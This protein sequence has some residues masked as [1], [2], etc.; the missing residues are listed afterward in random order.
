MSIKT[1]PNCGCLYATEHGEMFGGT[2]CRC[3]NRDGVPNDIAAL[4]AELAAAK[5]EIVALRTPIENLREA[6]RMSGLPTEAHDLLLART[7]ASYAHLELID[8]ET[9]R[10]A[11]E[12]LTANANLYPDLHQLLTGWH[13][14]VAWSEWDTHVFDQMILDQQKV[15]AA[16]A[17]LKGQP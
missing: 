12:A 4:R 8:R 9:L 7:S 17:A 14:D 11:V 1:C 2:P 5:A 10:K 16:L 15:E 3:G 13:C 6:R